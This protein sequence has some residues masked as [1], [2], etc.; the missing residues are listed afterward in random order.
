MEE[1]RAGYSLKRVA[2]GV[3][4]RMR[5]FTHK[6]EEDEIWVGLEEGWGKV[7]EIVENGKYK[8]RGGVGEGL[9]DRR[10]REV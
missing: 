2:Y 5:L 7:W 3:E 10:E 1:D 6:G 9:R 8:F 4:E